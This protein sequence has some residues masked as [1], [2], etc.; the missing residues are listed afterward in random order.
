MPF[1]AGEDGSFGKMFGGES[2]VPDFRSLPFP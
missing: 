1:V 2:L